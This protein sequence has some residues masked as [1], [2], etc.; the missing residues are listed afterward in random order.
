MPNVQEA[1][2]VSQCVQKAVMARLAWLELQK[3]Y[4]E[5]QPEPEPDVHPEPQPESLQDSHGVNSPRAE[6]GVPPDEALAADQT[7]VDAVIDEV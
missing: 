4:S 2:A 1:E 3:A 7:A 5:P 6:E